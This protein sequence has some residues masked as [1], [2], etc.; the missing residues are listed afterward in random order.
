[1]RKLLLILIGL[2]SMTVSAQTNQKV[3]DQT[4]KKDTVDVKELQEVVVVGKGVIDLAKD[5]KTPIAVSTI[6]L[7]FIM[8]VCSK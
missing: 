2:F 3:E 1:M 6:I 7:H 5:R 4:T 8:N